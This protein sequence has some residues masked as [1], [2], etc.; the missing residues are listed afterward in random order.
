MACRAWAHDG[1]DR[2][3]VINIIGL[4]E[5]YDTFA[6]VASQT[7]TK[8]NYTTHANESDWLTRRCS[9]WGYQLHAVDGIVYAMS[10]I[11]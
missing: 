2:V 7:G 6:L 9:L 10:V 5:V 1:H 3:Q 8:P 4:L 11:F